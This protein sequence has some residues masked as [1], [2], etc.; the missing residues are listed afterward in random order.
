[1]Q[2][3]EYFAPNNIILNTETRWYGNFKN[4]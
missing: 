2:D 3:D 1:M 4:N